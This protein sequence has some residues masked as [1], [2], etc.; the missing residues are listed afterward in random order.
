MDIN[1]T[2]ELLT[3]DPQR[4]PPTFPFEREIRL[5]QFKVW[6]Y[7][8]TS[9]EMV[10][11]A[12]RIVA[13][14]YLMHMESGVLPY[15]G[16]WDIPE[17]PRSAA[18]YEKLFKK[19]DYRAL[20]DAVIGEYGGWARLVETLAPSEFDESCRRRIEASETV[21]KMIDYRFR[22]LDHGGSDRQKANISHSEFFRWTDKKPPLS[23]R[24]IRQRWQAARQSAAFLYASENFDFTPREIRQMAFLRSLSGDAQ[25]MTRI[26]K[27]FGYA[28]YISEKLSGSSD[29]TIDIPSRVRRRR[30]PTKPLTDEEKERMQ[31]YDNRAERERMRRS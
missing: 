25:N 9:P 11:M 30:P 22:Y 26:R 14:W 10:R 5:F 18:E 19:P 21:R 4:R 13:S 23:W 28:A 27:F 3:A 6:I 24:T 2:I 8:P 31:K 16:L 12:G 17:E 20:F 29:V 1:E 7:F 15:D